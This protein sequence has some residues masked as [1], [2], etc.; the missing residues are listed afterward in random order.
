FTGKFAAAIGIDWRWFVLLDIRRALAPVEYVISRNVNERNVAATSLGRKQPRC[1]GVDCER[2]GFFAFGPID[3]G[4]TGGIDHRAPGLG[5]D[6]SR[7]RAWVR[8]IERGPAWRHD[9]NILGKGEGADLLTDLAS[10]AEKEEAHSSRAL[11]GE[12]AALVGV[13]RRQQRL[14]P[15]TVIEVPFHGRIE[16]SFKR[17]LR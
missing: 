15:G 12:A 14:P 6:Y 10:P 17:V 5:H 4:I 3:V 7:D 16:A 9:F 8:Q 11:L 1:F 2:N 13:V